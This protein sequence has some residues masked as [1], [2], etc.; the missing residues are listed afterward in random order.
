M[1]DC[2]RELRPRSGAVSASLPGFPTGGRLGCWVATF[3]GLTAA[4]LLGKW[5]CWPFAAV[6][7]LLL[8]VTRDR[9]EAVER[10]EARRVRRDVALHRRLAARKEVAAPGRVER[11]PAPA[12]QTVAR[13]TVS[14]E[15]LSPPRSSVT[16]IIVVASIAY[17]GFCWELVGRFS[18][19]GGPGLT[20]ALVVLMFIWLPAPIL[21]RR[22]AEHRRARER[23]VH[24]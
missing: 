17:V 18:S 22:F 14:R 1:I 24:R 21:Y 4:A 12:R 19:V 7:V 15:E 23:R 5:M 10:V 6:P 13:R 9:P 11:E 2:P 20:R 3:L 16:A 8:W